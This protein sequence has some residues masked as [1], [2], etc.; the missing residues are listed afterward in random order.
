[1]HGSINDVYEISLIFGD[2]SRKSDGSIDV[3][4]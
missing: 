2:E 3:K 1:M 4:V